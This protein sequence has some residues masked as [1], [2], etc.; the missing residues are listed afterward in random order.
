MYFL[1]QL[2]HT[3]HSFVVFVVVVVVDVV[4]VTNV[5][6]SAGKLQRKSIKLVHNLCAII[7]TQAYRLFC[8][9]SIIHVNKNVH[10]HMCVHIDIHM[11]IWTK[12]HTYVQKH[13]NFHKC[14]HMDTSVVH[15]S[16]N[17][18]RHM[19]ICKFRYVH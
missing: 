16:T 5:N 15:M 1:A 18:P 8:S 6:I 14:M 17:A 10:V 4:L 12:T 13:E 7:G 11:Y 3:D 9:L 19:C 2:Y